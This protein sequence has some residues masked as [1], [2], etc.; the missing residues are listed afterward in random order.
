MPT[1]GQRRTFCRGSTAASRDGNPLVDVNNP[2]GFVSHHCSDESSRGTDFSAARSISWN[3][4]LP[5]FDSS[6]TP[7][8]KHSRNTVGGW[9][10]SRAPSGRAA[11]TSGG[12]SK[13]SLDRG[14]SSELGL[15]PQLP[16]KGALLK[17][18]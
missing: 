15:P 8:N 2:I 12:V 3:V 5:L 13:Q 4:S 1:F 9:W 6:H 17:G 14:I 18:L 7:S 10:F 16:R 11:A